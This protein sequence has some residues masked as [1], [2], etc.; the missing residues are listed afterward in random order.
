MGL[1]K[2]SYAILDKIRQ[3]D[4]AMT[5]TLQ[6]A[7]REVHPEVAFCVLNGA[8]LTYG[9]KTT[10]GQQERVAILDRHGLTLDH[11]A[12]RQ[13]LGRGVGVDDVIDAAVCLLTAERISNQRQRVL[14][15]GVRDAKGL[16]VEIVA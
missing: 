13:R 8:P 9:K 12:V 14:G 2:Q 5:P 3:V 11:Q 10:D 6:L 7:V 16:A 4:Q 15:D 1:S